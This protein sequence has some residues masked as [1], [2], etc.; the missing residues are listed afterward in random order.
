MSI[1]LRKIKSALDTFFQQFNIKDY[2]IKGRI[3][4][5][6]TIPFIIGLQLPCFLCDS[7]DVRAYVT[8]VDVFRRNAS[9]GDVGVCFRNRILTP[10]LASFLPFDAYTSLQIVNFFFCI[11]T[12][13]ILFKYLK[14]F[15]FSDSNSLLGVIFFTFSF[16]YMYYGRVPLTDISALFFTILLLY[17]IKRD[18]NI[19]LIFTIISLGVLTRETVIFTLPIYYVYRY[20]N[21]GREVIWRYALGIVPIVVIP[22]VRIL[23]SNVVSEVATG[24]VWMPNLNRIFFNID[25]LFAFSDLDVWFTVLP[26][27]FLVPTYLARDKI[28]KIW[29]DQL[30]FLFITGVFLFCIPLYGFSA[31][32]FDGRFIWVLYPVSI[33]LILIGY[34]FWDDIFYLKGLKRGI[35]YILQRLT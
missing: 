10:M 35:D 13:V 21:T 32:Y 25:K 34:T 7:P 5:I 29:S 27:I 12:A 24:Y 30:K 17:M 20:L 14:L 26:F 4:I 1:G 9:F 22:L 28:I 31:A 15:E 8:L 3:L 6:S 23:I 18:Y 2:R 19:F 16:P 11:G 33:P